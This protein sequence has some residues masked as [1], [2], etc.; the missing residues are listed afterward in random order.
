MRHRSVRRDAESEIGPGIRGCA[1]AADVRRPR[2]VIRCVEALRPAGPEFEDRSP[3][4]RAADSILFCRDQG[5]MIDC[6]QDHR[7][8]QLRLNNRTADANDRFAGKNRRAFRDRPYVALK[9]EIPQ[10]ADKPGREESPTGQVC[11]VVFG[12]MQIREVFDD[13]FETRQDR[14]AAV[15]G[16]FPEEHIID[17]DLIAHPLLKI[18]V[19]HRQFIKIDEQRQIPVI[20]SLLMHSLDRKSVV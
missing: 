1:C 5:L 9:L 6:Q 15:V 3:L 18:S 19:P 13:L 12:K 2:A 11:Q 20:V 14:E 17:G 16:N 8:D 4:S 10:V 7:L